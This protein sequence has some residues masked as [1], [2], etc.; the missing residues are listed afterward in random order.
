M[1]KI[2][3]TLSLNF[4][5]VFLYLGPMEEEEGVEGEEEEVQEEEKGKK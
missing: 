1:Q 2:S 3:I 4:I 5:N